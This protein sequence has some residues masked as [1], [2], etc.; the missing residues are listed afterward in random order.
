LTHP[1]NYSFQQT[2][3]ALPIRELLNKKYANIGVGVGRDA[4]HLPSASQVFGKKSN[5]TKKELH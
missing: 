1:L 2:L 5:F 3:K 4:R